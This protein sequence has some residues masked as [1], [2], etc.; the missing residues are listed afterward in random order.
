MTNLPNSAATSGRMKMVSSISRQLV[1]VMPVKSMNSGFPSAFAWASDVLVKA[2]KDPEVQYLI[3]DEIGPLEMQGRGLHPVLD[4]LLES[5]IPGISFILVI[6]DYLLQ[7]VLDRYRIQDQ[8]REFHFPAE[9]A[10]R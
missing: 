6:R 2:L 10:G 4:D 8:A 1:H 5:P 9:Q 7:E 3:I